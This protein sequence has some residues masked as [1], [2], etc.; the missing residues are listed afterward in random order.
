VDQRVKFVTKAAAAVDGL[1]DGDG[2]FIRRVN[3][4]LLRA[5]VEEARRQV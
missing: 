2:N 4:D 3:E 5:I 1:D